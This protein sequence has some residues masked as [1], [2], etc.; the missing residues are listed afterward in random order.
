LSVLFAGGLQAQ[1][2]RKVLL[3]HFT[4]ASCGPCATYNPAMQAVVNANP[5]KI[6]PIKYQVWWPGSDPM[7]NHNTVDVQARV[8]YYPPSFGVPHSQLDGAWWGGH[9]ANWTINTVNTRYAVASPFQIEISHSIPAT[10]DTVFITMVIKAPAGFSG[11]AIAHIVVEEEQIHFS[12]APGSNGETDFF[13][14]MKKMLPSNAGTALPS[15][16]AAGDSVV[17]N[18]FWKFANVY[19]WEEIAV[20]GFIQDPVTKY[21][22]QAEYSPPLP[23]APLFNYD[24]AAL[25]LGGLP[26]ASC[27]GEIAPVV[28]IKNMGA[29]ALT[30]LNLNYRV[31]GGTLHTYAWTGNLP[32]YAEASVSLPVIT[33]P[34]QANNT[35]EVYPSLPNGQADQFAGNDTLQEEI[36]GAHTATNLVTL[37]LRTD[38]APAQTTW[39]LKDASGT[40]V[41][42]GGP[43]S[44]A[45]TMTTVPMTLSSLGCYTFTINDAGGNGI[46]CS[47]GIGF[48]RLTDQYGVNFIAGSNFASTEVGEFEVIGVGMEEELNAPLVEVVPNPFRQEARVQLNLDQAGE[49]GL[50]LFD[51]LGSRV[52]QTLPRPMPQGESTLSLDGSSLRPG[53]Y[54]LKVKVGNEVYTRKVNHTL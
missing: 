4:Q 38:N 37:T 45:Q 47:S 1:V 8:N 27:S 33:F 6:V 54:L 52:L 5:D 36:D 51:L 29:F 40:I 34:V 21:V 17:I 31:N 43:Y 28:K 42:S 12:T 10:H 50:E 16:W 53:L 46:C 11:S 44:Q 49:V 13:N 23:P 9:P 24:V 35:L 30:S 48:Y 22:H 20:V 15:T 25:T 3:E 26:T 18:A 7:Y 14:V 32:F 19:D 39:N 2:Q 41:Y